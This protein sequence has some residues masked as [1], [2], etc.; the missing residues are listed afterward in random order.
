MKEA[1]HSF[2]VNEI[3]YLETEAISNLGSQCVENSLNEIEKTSTKPSLIIEDT[4]KQHRRNANE[5]KIRYKVIKGY[6][7]G[8]KPIHKWKDGSHA[9]WGMHI[10]LS[11]CK[12]ECNEHTECE[13][14]V[15][16]HS[17]G[18]CGHWKSGPLTMT[19]Q[20][21]KDR[22]CYKKKNSSPSTRKHNNT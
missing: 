1:L 17:S 14:F 18:V 9:F 4:T 7:C 3:V 2:L 20:Y 21:G 19:E 10:D 8:G 12:E 15:A 5:I 11:K 16:V 6:S 13:G 22:D